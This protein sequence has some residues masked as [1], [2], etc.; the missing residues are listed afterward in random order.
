MNTYS[1]HLKNKYEIA[2]RT[3]AFVFEKPQGFQFQAGQYTAMTLPKL[4]FTDAKGATR[5]LSIASA[6]SDTEL[7]F[8]VRITETAFKKTLAGMPLGGEV[9]ICDATGHFILPEDQ[10]CK[11]V[12]LAGGIGIT[13]VRSILRQAAMEKRRNPFIL[14]YSNRRPEDAPFC[15]EVQNFSGLNYR[16]IDTLTRNEGVCDWQE[17]SG[18]ICAEMLKKY[19]TEIS[20]SLY[21]VVGTTGFIGAMEKIL[22][23]LGVPDANIKKDPFTG[24]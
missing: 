5:V 6:P 13:P 24:L 23:E 2:E 22:M 1:I 15:K 11:I 7:V 3:F 8:G 18:Y 12:F 16:C 20:Y 17:E 10:Q 19:L 9:M 4:D 14:F 21:Y